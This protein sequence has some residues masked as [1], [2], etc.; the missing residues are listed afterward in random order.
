MSIRSCQFSFSSLGSEIDSLFAEMETRA[1]ALMNQS[2]ASGLPAAVKNS[3]ISIFGNDFQIDLCETETEIIVTSDLPGL[4]KENISVR[5][6]DPDTLI[7]KAEQQQVET[8]QMDDAGTYHLRERRNG[9]MQRS[10]HL[11]SPVTNQGAKASFKNGVMEIVLQ[12][13]ITTEG[14]HI[15]IE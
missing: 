5:L 8:E 11:P 9:C 1:T 2:G 14:V 6:L 15:E 7:I 10:I 12:K 3:G 13:E 4:E